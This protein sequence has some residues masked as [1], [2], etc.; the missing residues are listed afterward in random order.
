MSKQAE[1]EF[2]EFPELL[3][4][5]VSLGRRLQ[6]PLLEFSQLCNPDNEILCLKYHPLQ[7]QLSD[8]ELL[9]GK[10]YFL[11]SSSICR[12][13]QF[14]YKSILCSG[15]GVPDKCW[16]K[17]FSERLKVIKLFATNNWYFF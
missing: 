8:E 14:W 2:R 6:D 17:P 9:E 13:R 7:D 10:Y 5:A 12:K 16:V 1:M 15:K 4:V 11:R 3:R